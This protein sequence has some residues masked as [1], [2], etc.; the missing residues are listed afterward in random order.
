MRRTRT[1]IAKALELYR[2]A[3]RE[4][5]AAGFSWEIEWQ[6][7][8]SFADVCEREFLRE[9]AWVILCSGFR[10]STVRKSFDYI[11]LCFCDWESA[12]EIA[13]NRVP[14]IATA[15]AV[16]NNTRKLSAIASVADVV[17]ESGFSTLKNEIR[18]DPMG[19]LQRLPF[20]GPITSQHLAKNLGLDMAKNDRHLARMALRYGYSCAQS[21]CDEISA[22]TG[23]SASVIDI[24]LWRFAAIAPGYLSA[25][26]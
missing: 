22:L 20:I 3:E 2:I 6:R 25:R 1:T 7:T 5:H 11:S 24:V 21:L 17:I 18:R 9:T 13:S 23:E 12:R 8:R 19:C 15:A 4:V 26:Y 16:F 14:C 10:E